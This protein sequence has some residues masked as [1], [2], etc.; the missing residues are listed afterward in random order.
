MED[1]LIPLTVVLLTANEADNIVKS[2]SSISWC[3]DVVVIDNSN[4]NTLELIR[5]IIL[6][7]NLTIVKEK[8]STNFSNLRNLG[9]KLTKNNWV[10]TGN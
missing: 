7:E 2:V 4:D 3:N 9:L 10:D 8:D 1:K 5:S 6:P